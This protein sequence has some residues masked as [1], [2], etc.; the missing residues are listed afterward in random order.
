MLNKGLEIIEACR[1]F[2]IPP[3]DVRVTIHPQ[4]TV[5]S[6]VEFVDGSILAQISVTDM[7]L[8][9]LYAMTYPERVDAERRRLAFDMRKLATSTLNRRTLSAFPV[10]GWPMRRRRR[11]ALT[12]SR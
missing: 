4:S 12:L 9:I 1:L 8:P 6:L 5:H 11:A 10:C 7:R 2:D 3:A